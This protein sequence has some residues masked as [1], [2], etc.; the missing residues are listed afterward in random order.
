MMRHRIFDTFTGPFVLFVDDDG[1]LGTSWLHADMQLLL[2]GSREDRALLPDLSRR[3][4]AYFAG[5]VVD[6][7]DVKIPEASDF[8]MRCWKACRSIRRG[9]TCTYAELAE[10]AGSTPGAARAAGQAMRNNPLPIII[11]CHRVIGSGGKLHGFGGSCDPSGTQL[12][13]KSAL[14]RMEMNAVAK[15]NAPARRPRQSSRG[16]ALVGAA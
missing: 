7:S 6:F 12:G 4:K 13:I 1:R 11:P 14:L 10:L 15:K 16:R 8:F 3:L 9:R 5:E 2:V